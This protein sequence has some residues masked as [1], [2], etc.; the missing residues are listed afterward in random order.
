MHVEC[1]ILQ[2]FALNTGGVVSDAGV[3][4]DRHVLCTG[5]EELGS[6]IALR[7]G[8]Y[9]PALAC[10]NLYDSDLCIC[11]RASGRICDRTHNGAGCVLF[12]RRQTDPQ[13]Q[14]GKEPRDAFHGR[15]RAATFHGVVV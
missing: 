2:D 9:E 4:R 14:Y 15:L 8:L 10:F 6:E 12:P 11:H 7:V 5:I 3:R 1:C 13:P